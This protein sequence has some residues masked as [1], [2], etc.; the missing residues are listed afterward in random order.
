MGWSEL[1]HIK[2]DKYL[3]MVYKYWIY[4]T[5][6]AFDLCLMAFRIYSTHE[7]L[8]TSIG[9]LQ[10]TLNGHSTKERYYLS[11]GDWIVFGLCYFSH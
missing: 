4:S 9:K 2:L 7:M 5:F 6:L 10:I 1:Q 11:I 8:V 3:L